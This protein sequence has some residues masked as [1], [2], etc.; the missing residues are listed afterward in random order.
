MPAATGKIRLS[1][2]AK[3]LFVVLGF[4]VLLP[5][6]MVWIVDRQTSD[7]VE[8]QA[9][10]A[11]T[12]AEVVFR[13]T[14]EIRERNLLARYRSAVMEPSF[15]AVVTQRDV[16]T[17][18]AYLRSLLGQPGEE[19][20]ALLFFPARGAAPVSARRDSAL[21]LDAFEHES[22]PLVGA[23]FD[24][25]GGIASAS[26]HGRAYTMIAMPV[27]FGGGGPV[28]GVLVSAIRS[29]EATLRE[30]KILTGT[31]VVLVADGGVLTSTLPATV[32]AAAWFAGLPAPE[33]GRPH[34]VTPVIVGTEHFHA[35]NVAYEP[36]TPADGVRYVLLAS[37]ERSA[38][39]LADIRQTL[40]AVSAAGILLSA[41]V[42]WFLVSRITQPLRELRD[43]AEAVGRG[44]FSRR[45]ERFPNDEC[46]DL[47]VAF[48]GMTANLQSST[49]ELKKAV[50]TLKSTQAQLIQS[51]KLSAVGQFVAGV[52]HE[53]NNPLTSVIGFADLL[54]MREA[55]EKNRRHLDLIAKSAHRC[56]KIVHSLLSFAR[57]HAPERKIVAVNDL[58][59]E[60]LEI[61]AYDLRTSNVTVV[62]EL[63]AGLPRIMA[64]PHQLQQVF[65]NILGNA[66]QAIEPFRRDGQI[67]VRTR[68][69]EGGVRVEF[70]DN[71]PGIRAENLARIFD[72]FFTT[73]PVGKGTG[74][75][76]SLSYGIIQEHGGK[77]A[78]R[79]EPGQG[80]TFVID[81]P[82][83]AE[84]PGAI[85]REA[86]APPFA[87]APRQEGQGKSVLVVDDEVWILQLAEELLRGEGYEVT[88]AASGARA[89]ELMARRNFDLVVCDWKMPGL[90]GLHLY[91]QLHSS[92]PAMAER[93][94]FMTGDVIN[95][96]FQKFL[97]AGDRPCLSKPFAI[98][99]FRA[100]VAR[101][102][103]RV[104]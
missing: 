4:L 78:A 92:H 94:I 60:V 77:I 47:A 19:G 31:E 103:R 12:T 86:S 55:D 14:L 74:L 11:L 102:M 65:V 51:E 84:P 10:Q 27:M 79:S 91:E 45:V 63:A 88:T 20:E 76:L 53:L 67:V 30:W 7:L 90:S 21:A 3:V 57:Q 87:A 34:E 24:G 36:D 28:V 29:G 73:K 96:T 26:W 61:M 49:A 40:V 82:V 25:E 38:R 9:R 23:A 17:M 35:L 89:L 71:G 22:A 39:A 18:A 1:V 64:D 43:S 8:D 100:T 42:I 98:A 50:E 48:N 95:D 83:A 85:T 46:G 62:K 66:R 75:G 69:A 58:I 97:E 6:L 33:R 70:Q 81:L 68:L 41:L 54:S 15:K 13:K 44:D 2:Q 99:E 101:V 37:Y 52:A 104:G 72:P 93:M 5:L 56:H 16:P 80:A 32:D 59:D